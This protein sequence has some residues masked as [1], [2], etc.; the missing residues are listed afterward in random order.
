MIAGVR[1]ME[2]LTVYCM[3]KAALSHL[4]QILAVEWAKHDIRVN[5]I[6]PGYLHTE[7]NDAFFETDDGKAFLQRF[8]GRRVGSAG[9]LDGVL[10][11]LATS[12]SRFMTGQTIVVDDG[13][14]LVL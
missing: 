12:A 13:Y 3:S 6:A 5:A 9:D 10:M 8:L 1:P 4:T 7:A 11:L 14:T 2:M